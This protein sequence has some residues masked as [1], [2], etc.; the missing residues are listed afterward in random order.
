[1]KR[2]WTSV[3]SFC[4]L[5][6]FVLNNGQI[7]SHCEI[8]CGIYG[9]EI[10]LNLLGEHI[11]TVEKSIKQIVSLSSESKQNSNQLVRWVNNKEQHAL[12][13]QDIATQYF[14]T[15]R[16][17]PADEKE[18]KLYKVYIEQITLLHN[19][20]IYAMKA[21]QSTELENIETLRSLLSSFKKSYL[22]HTHK[23]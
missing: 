15:Q 20:V 7:Y 17:K 16:V 8:P 18:K 12:L 19:I 1:M 22:T 11:T 3:L 6:I 2:K 14:M 4:F 13:I 9:D 21:K 10:R 5:G 23:K